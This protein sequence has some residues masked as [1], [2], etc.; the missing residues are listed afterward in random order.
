MFGMTSLV[1]RLFFRERDETVQGLH[2]EADRTVDDMIDNLKAHVIARIESRMATQPKDV[3]DAEWYPAPLPESQ[4]ITFQQPLEA[5]VAAA[6]GK[7]KRTTLRKPSRK[8]KA[9]KAAKARKAA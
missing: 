3:I 5:P 1:R 6:N 4:R 9:T 8:A 7:P 2:K